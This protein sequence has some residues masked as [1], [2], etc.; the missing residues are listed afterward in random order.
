MR[1]V[2]YPSLM[3]LLLLI[4]VSPAMAA[5]NEKTKTLATKIDV[6]CV[7]DSME[8]RDAVIGASW[9]SY[10]LAIKQALGTRKDGLRAAW[11]KTDA[12]MIKPAIQRVWTQFK[13]A[14]TDARKAWLTGKKTAWKTFY[15]DR[16]TC[17][18]TVASQ[19]LTTEAVDADTN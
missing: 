19:D 17:G 1:N 4:T 6:Q 5:K 11:A 2:L 9:D 3:F 15:A 18:R 14:K 10:S 12:A 8:K 13:R 7:Q 16:K